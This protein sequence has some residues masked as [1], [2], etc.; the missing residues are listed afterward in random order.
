MAI[1]PFSGSSSC[2]V[3]VLLP[4][5]RP[6]SSSSLFYII[7]LV[8]VL[9]IWLEGMPSLFPSCLVRWPVLFSMQKLKKIYIYIYIKSE[10]LGHVVDGRVLRVWKKLWVLPFSMEPDPLH[11][12]VKWRGSSSRWGL[13]PKLSRAKNVPHHL[14]WKHTLNPS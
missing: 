11:F 3:L 9:K 2:T 10:F 5:S 13:S 6:T 14:K 1:A 12:K 7:S 8:G 4:S